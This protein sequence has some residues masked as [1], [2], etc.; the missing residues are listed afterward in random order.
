MTLLPVLDDNGMLLDNESHNK[1]G[2][3]VAAPLLQMPDFNSLIA[4]SQEHQTPIYE[5]TAEQLDQQG[6]V[7]DATQA[8]QEAFHKLFSDAADR[9]IAAIDAD[10]A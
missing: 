6:T 5:L 7:L 1:A 4:R 10:R 8:S 3:E 9:V 2:Y